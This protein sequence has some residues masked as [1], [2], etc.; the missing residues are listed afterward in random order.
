[1]AGAPWRHGCATPIVAITIALPVPSSVHPLLARLGLR[2]PIVQAPMAGVSSVAMAAA[3]AAGGGLGSLAIGAMTAAQARRGIHEFRQHSTAQL[4][5]NVFVHQP[6][7]ADPHKERAWLEHLRPQF[8]QA[9]AQPPGRLREIYPSFLTD[10]PMLDVL[11]TEA[12]AVVSFHFGVPAR[13]HVDALHRAG[14]TLFASV[15]NLNE[16]L[17]VQ[18]A[19]VDAVIAQG[20]EAGG[21]RGTFEPDAGDTQLTTFALTRILV[22]NLA[23]PVLA[24]GAIMDG[25]A[26]AAALELGACAAQLG[27]AFIGTP[28]SLADAAY[29]ARLFSSAAHRTVMTRVISGRPARCLENDFTRWGARI[30][31]AAIPDYPMAYDAGKALHAAACAAGNTGYGAQ[32]AG[33]GAPLARRMSTRELMR[34]LESELDDARQANHD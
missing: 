7:S 24:A 5:V 2:L 26:I 11:A 3:V 31:C 22:A 18:A 16:A 30:D 33:Q 13:R 27:T 4:N 34:A 19:G 8:E 21:H 25:A 9:G 12:P 23:L 10:E 1:M 28:E 17:A 6:A 32:W 14:S 29:R 15:T 20:F